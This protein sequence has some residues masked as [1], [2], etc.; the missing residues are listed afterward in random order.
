M[1]AQSALALCLLFA[2]CAPRLQPPGTDTVTPHLAG[3]AF[4]AADGARLPMRAWRPEGAPRAVVLAVHG[5]NDYANAF[6][7]VG[8]FLAGRGVAVYAYDQRGFGATAHPGLWP[9]RAALVADL[10]AVAETLRA[11]HAGARLHLMGESMGG[12]VV[13]VAMTGPAPPAVDGVILVAPAVWARRTMPWYQ[14]GALWLAAHTVPWLRLTGRG[15]DIRASDNDEMLRALAK[16][17][18]FIKETRVDALWGIANL[19][20]D[21]LDA[22]PRFAAPALILY[23]EKDEIIPRKPTFRMLRALPA[24]AAGRRRIALYDQGWHMLLRDLAA[25]TVWEDMASW[26]ADPAAPLPSGADARARKAL[27]AAE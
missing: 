17:P 4:T 24:A 15:L 25:R 20:D 16:D 9:G 10:K 12:A 11:E 1:K 3:D 23:G 26:L 19:M 21:A 22:A 7:D 6:A 14:R 8:P 2:A 18:L 27:A 13:M 5:F